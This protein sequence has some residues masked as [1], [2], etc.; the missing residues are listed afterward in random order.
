MMKEEEVQMESI[1]QDHE[2]RIVELEKQAVENKNQYLRLE[3]TVMQSSRSTENLLNKVLDKVLDL[4][5]VETQQEHEFRTAENQQEHDLA[6]TR[7]VSR[8]EIWLAIFGSGG[9]AAAIVTG[10]FAYLQ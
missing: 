6:K 1:V 8:K 9:L 5:A 3:N 7:T 10:I 2:R 4:R